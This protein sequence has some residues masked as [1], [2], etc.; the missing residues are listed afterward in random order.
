MVAIHLLHPLHP[1]I[2]LDEGDPVA[3]LLEVQPRH[4]PQPLRDEG[5]ARILKGKEH[6]ASSGGQPA[7]RE[8]VADEG[9]PGAPGSGNEGGGSQGPPLGKK[10][11]EPGLGDVQR[12][13]DRVLPFFGFSVVFKGLE[14]FSGGQQKDDSTHDQ[15]D[16]EVEDLEDHEGSFGDGQKG[17]GPMTVLHDGT[18]HQDSNRE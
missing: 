13:H 11:R 14:G 4:P 15:T 17:Q 8:R 1:G 6:D 10:L 18:R 3:K 2:Q 9:L 12:V 7:R 16:G 5:V